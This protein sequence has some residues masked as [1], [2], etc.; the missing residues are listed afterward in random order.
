MFLILSDRV[1][2]V[3][4]TVGVGQRKGGDLAERKVP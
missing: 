2:V 4:G 1:E 3:P